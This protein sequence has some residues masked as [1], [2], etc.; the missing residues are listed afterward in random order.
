VLLSRSAISANPRC[1]LPS[2]PKIEGGDS[3]PVTAWPSPSV[4][5]FG[6]RD[7]K[8][9]R[10]RFITEGALLRH[11]GRNDPH[12]SNTN[13][14]RRGGGCN[15]HR[16]GYNWLYHQRWSEGDSTQQG[17][18]STRPSSSTTHST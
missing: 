8:L 4:A 6:S 1:F 18:G 16:H 13:Q 11:G 17:D 14:D 9:S 7:R 15:H 3:G 2:P 12:S 5:G 10:S